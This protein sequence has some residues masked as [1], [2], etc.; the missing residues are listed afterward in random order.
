M[1]DEM[2]ERQLEQRGLRDAD[3]LA[4]M[5]SVPRERFVPV[6]QQSR[7]YADN[8]LPIGHG[9]TISQPYIVALMTDALK[10]PAWR[11]AH[12]NEQPRVLDV[13]TGSGYQAAV[14]AAMGAAVVSIERDPVLAEEARTRLSELGYLVEVIIGDGSA[15][16]PEHAPFA[17]IIAAAAAPAIPEPLVAQLADGARL[18]VPVGGRASQ[19]LTVVRREGARTVVESMEAAVFVPLVGEHG[20]PER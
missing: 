10:L 13:G 15:G 7:A 18:V 1:R 14:L 20:F 11:L 16:A 4:A 5:R 2:V 6:D 9:Q 19:Q 8:A 12:P 17:G 3:V